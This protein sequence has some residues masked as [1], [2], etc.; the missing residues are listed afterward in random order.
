MSFRMMIFILTA[1]LLL[2]SALLVK[3]KM[4]ERR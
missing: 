4:I 3:V 1:I 2:F